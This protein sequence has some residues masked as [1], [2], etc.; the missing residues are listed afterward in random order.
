MP[1][2]NYP[3]IILLKYLNVFPFPALTSL[4]TINYP[5]MDPALAPKPHREAGIKSFE[6]Q[7]QKLP[8]RSPQSTEPPCRFLHMLIRH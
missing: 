3:F 8:V 5:D 1:K 2:L 4:H 6:G 7:S